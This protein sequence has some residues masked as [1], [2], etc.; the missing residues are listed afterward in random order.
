MSNYQ[1][2]CLPISSN[3]RLIL[4]CCISNA[5]K[6]KVLLKKFAVN[7]GCADK[8]HTP[9][10]GY[11]DSLHM[12]IIHAKH[13]FGGK[14]GLINQHHI[15]LRVITD[16]KGKI[17]IIKGG[18]KSARREVYLGPLRQLKK[19]FLLN[20]LNIRQHLSNHILI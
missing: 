10:L 4:L 7:G 19:S 16:V 11:A 1:R 20:T 9:I 5:D 14:G 15:G 6:C 17:I 3:K 18:N 2:K 13:L 12:A 8:Q